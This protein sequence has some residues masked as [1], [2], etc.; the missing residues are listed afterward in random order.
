MPHSKHS[1]STFAVKSRGGQRIVAIQRCIGWS[2]TYSSMLPGTLDTRTSC[3]A[4]STV[5]SATSRKLQRSRPR[6]S[7]LGNAPRP[8]RSGRQG[9]RWNA[10]GVVPPSR[11]AQLANV[12]IYA[13]PL[14]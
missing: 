6:C 11:C 2:C 14:Q 10:T 13:Y 12:A 5:L 7:H 9:S 3:G 4:K 1:I 8:G